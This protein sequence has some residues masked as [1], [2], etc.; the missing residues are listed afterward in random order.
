[1]KSL[2]RNNFIYTV[3]G[4]ISLL[5]LADILVTYWNN[6]IISDNRALQHEAETIKLFTEQIGKSTIHG[7]DIGLR[8]Y[9]LVRNNQFFSPVDSAFL[10]KDSILT[11]IETRL[12]SQGYKGLPE[13]YALKDSLNN[14]F[15]Y[16]FY[17]KTLLDNKKDDEFMR[18][19]Q[20]DKGLYLWLQYLQCQRNI[21]LFEDRI[22]DEAQQRYDAALRGNYIL[23]IVLF[24]ICVP[25]L[26]Y[27]AFYTRKTMALSDQLRQT[28]A[29][30]N[31]LLTE[32]NIVL[33]KMVAERTQEILARSEEMQAQSDEIATQ[34]DVLAMQ[35]AKLQEAQ[36]II[37][38]QKQQLE[39]EV[40]DRTQDLKL[41][42]DELIRQNNQLEQ[43]AFIS[44]HNLR[45]P[46]ARILGLANVLEHSAEGD[47]RNIIIQKMISSSRDLD[48]VI[49][50]LNTILDIRKH[51]SNLEEVKLPD[52]LVRA[53]KSLEREIETTQT[54][55]AI[56]FT[57]AD[58][59]TGV[60][61]YVESILY[62][63]LSNAIKYRHPN[64]TP[65]IEIKTE[66]LD[67]FICLTVSDNGLG[68]DLAQHKGNLFGLY[69]RFHLHMEGRGLGLYLI[70]T[71]LIAMGG[72]V[73]LKSEPEKGTTFILYFKR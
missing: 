48:Q 51:N 52:T 58:H 39:V 44:A 27:T 6:Q 20:S 24:L 30:N 34:R 8:G 53:M 18:Y 47:E 60:A 50:D 9:A 32:Q 31:K 37:E 19:F 64:R 26:L 25:T 16:C 7:I 2:F 43:F 49:R 15:K 10:R 35:N 11:N 62:N 54:R 67:D 23:Q 22:N 29:K 42:N 14:Y 46:L 73:D 71:Q 1:M 56:D 63:L 61:P 40:D 41:A 13:F 57:Q 17:L 59:V 69:K 5:L 12:I 21:A 70:K 3:V 72:T 36:F 38:K 65:F 28:E 4:I 66:V 33:E 68:I 45:A 55:L